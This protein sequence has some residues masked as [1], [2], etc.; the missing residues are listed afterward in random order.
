[1][2]ENRID[3]AAFCLYDW[4]WRWAAPLLRHHP[5][6]LDGFDQRMGH[7]LP[8]GPVD[9][10][11]Q[12]ASAGESYLTAAIIENLHPPRPTR[13][14]LTA[15]TRQGIDILN[16]SI[17][18]TARLGSSIQYESAF[19]PFDRPRIM[20]AAVAHF[21]PAV[22]VLLETEIWP[23]LLSAL[24]A[25]GCPSVIINGRI[26]KKS[27]RR[28]RMRPSLWRAIGPDRVLAIS[29]ADAARY[30]ELFG[31]QKVGRM[32]NIKFDR[33]LVSSGRPKDERNP[34]RPLACPSADWLVLGSIRKEEEPV[35]EPLLAELARRLP[36][37]VIALFPRHL[38]R[39]CAW[40]A[41]L[42]GRGLRW[43]LRSAIDRPQPA[44]TVILWDTFG[45]LANAYA[46][47][48]AAFIGGSLAPLGGQNF[49]EP[50]EYGIRSV[51]GPF[52]DNFAW[53]GQE[54]L[55]RGLVRQR[56]DWQG[57]AEVLVEDMAKPP[58]CENTRRQARAYIQKRQGGTRQACA[59]IE[60]YLA[61]RA[62]PT[63]ET[64]SL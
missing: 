39:L 6:L 22:M 57:V 17:R 19:F 40:Q 43:V 21:R 61:R 44:G 51:I 9:I 36:A 34:L 13:V 63:R 5:R 49:L 33:L 28:Y 62:E 55:S 16:R 12:A 26:T 31:R 15:N 27:Q 8:P 2:F 23:G 56:A 50:L 29:Q 14:L 59:L 35:V 25:H 64:P 10:W 48:K 3:Q 42:T 1:V 30:A 53:V 7:L 37:A 45:E 58:D 54:I 24:K 18:K 47:A 41:I 20:N 38:D 46:L 52:W 32:P 11:I 4:G 60:S